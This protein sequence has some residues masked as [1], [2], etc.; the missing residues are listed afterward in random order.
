MTWKPEAP[1]NDLPLL[2]P[3]QEIETKAI[4]RATAEARASLATL[5][6]VIRFIPDPAILLNALPLI[7]AQASS[8][9]E[10]IMTT[11][12]DLFQHFEQETVSVSPEIKETFRYRSAIFSA[13]EYLATRPLSFT[14]AQHV[15]SEIKN[16]EMTVRT[17]P[18]TFIGN[19]VSGEA[20][21]TPP[22]GDEVLRT[23]IKNWED[24]LHSRTELDPLISMAVMHYQFEAIHPFS[25]GN[26][27]TGRVLNILFLLEKGLLSLPI[28]YLSRY[29]I[30]H[31]ADYYSKLLAVTRDAQWEDW[32]LFM[33]RAVRETCDRTI[34]HVEEI[35]SL[36]NAYTSLLR[37]IPGVKNEPFLVDVLFAKP[38][39]RI[40]DVAEKCQVTRMTAA[41]WLGSLQKAGLIEDKKVGRNR[42]FINRKFFEILKS[43]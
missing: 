5:N 10:N 38:F 26:G 27:R 22:L 20:V 36:Y 15:C 25:D 14:L 42:I 39:F 13:V 32:I 31:K 28:L 35:S 6:Q 43:I 1:Y 17:L 18:G 29:I 3:V 9:I 30:I 23:L 41:K 40:S 7:E 37:E 4:L 33:L 11:R 34:D 19:P 21:Y 2:P 24:F 12:D 16:R 8:E